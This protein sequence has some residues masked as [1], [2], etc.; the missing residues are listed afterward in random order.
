MTRGFDPLSCKQGKR[1]EN[2]VTSSSTARLGAFALAAL[3]LF[4]TVLLLL[5]IDANARRS[6]ELLER[7]L[8]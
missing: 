4:G 3:V 5:D 6:R 8:G 7:R 2:H 1:E